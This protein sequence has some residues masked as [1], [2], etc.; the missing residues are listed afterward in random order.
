MKWGTFAYH[1][2]PFGLINVGETF[3]CVM[4]IK[5]KIPINKIVLVYLNDVTFIQRRYHTILNT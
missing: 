5:F 1:W 4:D 2:M 3:Q